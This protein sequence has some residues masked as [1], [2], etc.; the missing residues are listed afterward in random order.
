[1]RKER[2]FGDGIFRGRFI[3]LDEIFFG[4][5]LKGS[6]YYGKIKGWLLKNIGFEFYF[7]Y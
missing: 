4:L 7:Y 6:M 1:M 5:F 3:N 2:S